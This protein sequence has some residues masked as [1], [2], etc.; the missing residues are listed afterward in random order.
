MQIK[1]FK[2]LLGIFFLQFLIQKNNAQIPTYIGG[3]LNLA[4]N[5]NSTNLGLN[6][7]LMYS[8]NDYVDLGGGLIFNYYN[9]TFNQVD[10]TKINYGLS[11][12][13]RCWLSNRFCITLQ[14]E[15]NFINTNAK[16]SIVQSNYKTSLS[17]P[18]LLL[19]IGYG[20]R[21]VS[22]N[23]YSINIM[24]DLIN[25]KNSPYYQD[26]SKSYTPIIRAGIGIYLR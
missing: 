9:T 8:I 6:P 26:N 2:L 7:E 21:N 12:I 5:S 23:V 24:V 17:A 20:S 22:E 19:G 11:A 16:S 1:Y 4:F 25:D 3:N 18:A 14:P 10:L 15:F 13:S